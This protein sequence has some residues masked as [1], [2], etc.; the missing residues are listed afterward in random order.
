MDRHQLRHPAV[1]CFL[2]AV[3][4]LAAYWSVARCD[5]LNFDDPTYVTDN[6]VV[7][8]GLTWRGVVWAFTRVHGSNWHPLTWL[9]HMADCQLFGVHPA[10]H[11]LVNLA[12]HLANCFLLFGLLRR[13]TRAVW[14]SA[15][16]AALFAL[17]P[18]HVESVAWVAERK[19]VLS[20]FFGLL[21]LGAYAGYAEVQS[22]KSK[23]QSQGT[24]NTQHAPRYYVLSLFLFAL[25]L[26][27]K[28]MLVTLPFVLL[29]LDYWPLQRFALSA[30]CLPILRRLFL[31]KLP[32]FALAALSCAIT[33]WAQRHGGAVMS[34]EAFPAG[35]RVAN[36]ALSYWWYLQKMLW[37]VRLAIFYPHTHPQLTGLAWAALIALMMVT[38]AA[39][40]FRKHPYLAVGWL[41]F[42]GTLV[43]VI[44]LVQVG[45]QGMADRYSYLPSIGLLIALAFG[46][47]ELVT[48]NRGRGRE[49]A[50]SVSRQ[51]PQSRPA[52]ASKWP[53]RLVAA[54]AGLILSACLVATHQQ[55]LCWHDSETVFRHALAVTKGNYAAY[56]NLGIVLDSQGKRDQAIACYE[57]SLRSKPDQE[58]AHNNLA[59]VLMDR[60]LLAEAETHVRLALRYNPRSAPA[61][62]TLS[63]L[64][65]CR[66]DTPGAIAA[67]RKA[68]A[69]QPGSPEAHNN[70]GC[71]LEAQGRYDEAITHFQRALGYCPELTEAL[72]NLGRTL[73]EQGRAAQ[74]VS[75][76]RTAVQL[77]PEYAEAHFNLG[78]ACSV[79]KLRAQA[80]AEY[81]TTLRLNP[82]NAWAHYK[83]GNVYLVQ[84]NAAA[85]E[86]Y[87]AALSLDPNLAEAHYHLALVF[88]ARKEMEEALK[89]Y[90]EAVRAKPD[91][92]VA[93]NNLAWLLATHADARFRS[94]AEALRLAQHAAQLAKHEDAE[95]LDTLAAAYAEAGRFPEAVKTARRAVELAQS[96]D[97]KELTGQIQVRL[98]LY[99][100]GQPYREP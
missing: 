42:T 56:N 72:N 96:A 41:W 71:L 92:D 27:S 57:A 3:L 54:L 61:H 64:L 5:F 25:G 22:L 58:I 90:R 24:R 28:P 23:V 77:K 39:V 59:N 18:L 29:L 83:M 70:L 13:L 31:E 33:F 80:L 45:T 88:V 86:Q 49:S 48:L 62:G 1:I 63:R 66:G 89:Q 84:D 8:H 15:L 94:G 75:P 35:T 32:F 79:L 93:L 34:A 21:S 4:T 16:V 95:T 52:G 26:M 91:W 81:Q 53:G 20:A 37:P 12:L 98:H 78:N 47:R 55:V 51:Q 76:L 19:D 11:H 36:A 44:G 82:T 6:L 10:G 67:A 85:A 2:L 100:S 65:Q 46:L 87:R 99:Q 30:S 38:V 60:N 50:H 97:Q 7:K 73:T 14:P 40:V 74:A 69:L 9:S 43:P 68:L 17:H